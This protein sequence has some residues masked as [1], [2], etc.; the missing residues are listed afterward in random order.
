MAGLEY[1]Q[2]MASLPALGPILAAKEAPISARRLMKRLQDM[3]SPAHQAELSAAS[4]LLVW[5]R[6]PLLTS[7]EDYLRLAAATLPKLSNP[8]VRRLVLDRLAQRTVVA[9]LRRREAGQDAPAAD[10][11]WGY[12]EVASRIR[13]HWREP[14]FGLGPAF[15]WVLPLKEMIAAGDA[16]GVERM[17]LE[18]A[19]RTALRLANPHDFDF[20]AVAIY[21]ARWH[22]LIRW[23]R[24]DAEVAAA[25]FGEL[26]AEALDDARQSNQLDLDDREAAA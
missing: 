11:V 3:L 18:N 19:W 20:E 17:L 5:S 9:A 6:L 8:T 13:K 21:V 15:K 26:I 4:E 10:L 22:L 24:Y 25:R 2:L 16:A 1:V 12:G 23:T 7:D 14:G